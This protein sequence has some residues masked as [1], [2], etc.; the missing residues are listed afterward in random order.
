[1]ALA[2]AL[3][4]APVSTVEPQVVPVGYA[5]GEL[6]PNALPGPRYYVALGDSYS[7]AEGAPY[8]DPGELKREY[9]ADRLEELGQLAPVAEDDLGWLGDTGNSGDRCHRS[10]HAYAARVWGV[11]DAEDPGWGVSFRACSGATTRAFLESFKSNPPQV[12]AFDGRQAD[13]VTLGFGGNNIGFGGIVEDCVR[14][15]I[16]KRYAANN[17]T[18][19]VAECQRKWSPRVE[20]WLR[21]VRADLRAI[22]THVRNPAAF[23]EPERVK[24]DG[25]VMAV[26]YPRPFPDQP[27]GACSLGTA[28]SIAVATQR[29]INND[30]VDPLNAAIREEAQAAGVFYVDTS[31]YFSRPVRHDFC[32]DDGSDRWINRIIPSDPQRSVHPKFAYHE[33]VAEAV[34][35]CWRGAADP[36]TTVC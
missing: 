11:L 26:G 20:G 22:V 30:V 31:S 25:K 34:L 3:V 15:A 1:M 18:N 7:S 29:W 6:G 9:G 8:V 23:G 17:A 2:L 10:A 35:A 24:P 28:S 27:S 13:L 5:E 36:R 14:E 19:F 12:D 21:D 33:R 16:A 32:L 4:L